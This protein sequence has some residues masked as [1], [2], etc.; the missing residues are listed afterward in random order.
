MKIY[1]IWGDTNGDDG[2]PLVGEASLA[3]GTLCYGDVVNGNT[4]YDG[5]DVL[6]I[7]FTGQDAVP[8]KK[9]AA[10]EANSTATFEASIQTLGDT[11]ISRLTV[12]QSSSPRSGVSRGLMVTLMPLLLCWLGD[13]F[14]AGAVTP[15]TYWRN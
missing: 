14:W 1:A 6:Y 3:T 15:S 13:I 4:G 7:A 9:G 12:P 8:G 5:T 10:W 2:P 11:L